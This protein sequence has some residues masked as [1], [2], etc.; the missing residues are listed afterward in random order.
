MR[1]CLQ[2]ADARGREDARGLIEIQRGRGAEICVVFFTV[3]VCL[4]KGLIVRIYIEVYYI[5]WY[6]EIYF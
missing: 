3:R 2:I 5:M 4:F 6:V 1:V